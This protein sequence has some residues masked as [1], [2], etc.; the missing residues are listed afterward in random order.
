ML[1][2]KLGDFAPQRDKHVH[3]GAHRGVVVETDEG[4]H[5][6]TLG[7]EHDLD[8]DQARRLKDSASDLVQK[9]QPREL[10]L[11][12]AGD[13]HTEHDDDNVEEGRHGGIGDAPEPGEE[14]HHDGRGRLEHL[15]KGHRE[16]E[17]DDIGADERA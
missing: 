6:Q 1:D 7:A 2:L 16:V 4:V 15:D 12:R 3:D 10:D 11:A 13:S 14:E 8:Q 5:L 17:V 9:P